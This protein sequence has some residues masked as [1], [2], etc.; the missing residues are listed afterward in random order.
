M[1]SMLVGLFV[2]ALIILMRIILPYYLVFLVS[3]LL[4]FQVSTR[5]GR[6]V[7]A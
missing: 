6:E 2:P 1:Y 7:K 3:A 4:A 5:F